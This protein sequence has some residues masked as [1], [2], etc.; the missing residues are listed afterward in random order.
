MFGANSNAEQ[1]PHVTVYLRDSAIVPAAVKFRAEAL[2]SAM[3][4]GIGVRVDWRAGQLAPSS[5]NG[6]VAIELVTE[7]P[8][9]L[10]RGAVAYALP[11]EGVHIPV[12]YDRISGAPA[13]ISFFFVSQAG[14]SGGHFVRAN[15]GELPRAPL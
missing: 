15:T 7:T 3:F 6:S 5:P 2:A 9:T 1:V 8:A 12:F 4:A 14:I 11:Y 13:R 10:M